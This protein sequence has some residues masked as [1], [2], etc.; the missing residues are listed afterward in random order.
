[1]KMKQEEKNIMEMQVG[2]VKH[3]WKKVI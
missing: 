3:L 2:K 1:M